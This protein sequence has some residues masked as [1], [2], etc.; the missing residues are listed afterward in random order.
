M[1]RHEEAMMK[2]LLLAAVA[3]LSSF[4]ASPASAG[5]NPFIGEVETFA[6]NFCPQG[7][8]PL[9]GRLLPI[10]QNQALFSLLGTTYGGDGKTTFALPTGKAVFTL[11]PG[12]PQLLQCIAILGIFPSRN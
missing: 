3:A 12:N 11:S 4:V 10:N 6:F 8:L 7:W 2:R 9:D 1:R 5:S